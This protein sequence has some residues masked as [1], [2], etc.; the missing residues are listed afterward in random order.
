MDAFSTNKSQDDNKVKPS[1]VLGGIMGGFDEIGFEMETPSVS[2]V[3]D[4]VGGIFSDIFS[5]GQ[6]IVGAEPKEASAES[7]KF[8]SKGTIE[9]NKN[10]ARAQQQLKEKEQTDKKKAFYQTLKDDQ[11]RAQMAKDRMWMEEEINDLTSNMSTE[12]KNELLH[13]QASYK[14]RSIYQKAEL[15][16]KIIE[17]RRKSE[18][19]QKDAS[20]PSPAKQASALETAF[21]GGSGSQGGGT[22]NLSAHATG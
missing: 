10:E 20:I 17:Q 8:P 1:Q 12:E 13:Y 18:N 15:R 16:R 9:F 22:A 4:G 6:D 7:N 2:S 14:D 21:E 19:Q 11:V 5:L 3:V